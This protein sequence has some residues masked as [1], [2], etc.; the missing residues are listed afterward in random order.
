MDRLIVKE[1][2]RDIIKVYFW[3]VRDRQSKRNRGINRLI[4]RKIDDTIRGIVFVEFG[5]TI[6]TV[7]GASIRQITR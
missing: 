1:A 4:S 5:A 6:R 7:G 2:L 3:S